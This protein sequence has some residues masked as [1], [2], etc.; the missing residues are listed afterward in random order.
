VTL[1]DVAN[2][3]AVLE[4]RCQLVE[5]ALARLEHRL[6]ELDALKQAVGDLRFESED[7]REV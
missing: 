4:R 6:V 1:T 3:L 7:M 2:R 5:E